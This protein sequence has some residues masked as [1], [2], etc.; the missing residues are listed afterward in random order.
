MRRLS[1]TA[2]ALFVSLICFGEVHTENI[3]SG[4]KF[5]QAPGKESIARLASVSNSDG[6]WLDASVPGTVHSD[7][8]ASGKIGDPYFR[9]NEKGLQWIDKTDWEYK[10]S[11]TVSGET[12]SNKN[13]ILRFE[14]LDTYAKVFLFN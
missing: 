7:L 13:I 12:A 2:I 14:G 11:F 10:T 8:R 6:V 5:R 9:T 3:S 4:W 1:L